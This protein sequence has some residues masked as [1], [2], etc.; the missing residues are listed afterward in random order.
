MKSISRLVSLISLLAV[1]VIC[2]AAQ[3]STGSISGT[4]TDER[5]AVIPGATVTIKNT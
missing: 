1:L 2:A 5:Q 4:V 3:S